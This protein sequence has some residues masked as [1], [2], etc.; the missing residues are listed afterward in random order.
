MCGS[1]SVFRTRIQEAPEYGSG[2]TSLGQAT[3][4]SLPDKHLRQI[5]GIGSRD[6]VF[7]DEP[8]VFEYCSIQNVYVYSPPLR[9]LST[10]AVYSP[11]L[12]VLSTPRVYSPP[13]PGTHIQE[14][15]ISVS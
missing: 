2:S 7:S 15:P 6:N 3:N 14:A 9:V 11:P 5:F 10:P 4:F 13:L 12:R 8:Y 1:G